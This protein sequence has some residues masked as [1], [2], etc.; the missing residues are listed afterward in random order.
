MNKNRRTDQVTAT[1]YALPDGHWDEIVAACCPHM[2]PIIL[3]IKGGSQ[4]PDKTGT[5]QAIAS[6]DTDMV[7]FAEKIRRPTSLTKIIRDKNDIPSQYDLILRGL[8]DGTLAWDY[9]RDRQIGRGTITQMIST[10][11]IIFDPNNIGPKIQAEAKAYYDQGPLA[12]EYHSMIECQ[13]K[14]RDDVANNRTQSENHRLIAG[15]VLLQNIARAV[16]RIRKQWTAK[17]KIL[18]RMFNYYGALDINEHLFQAFINYQNGNAEPFHQI[19]NTFP[20]LH[21][22]DA[23][24]AV[25]YHKNFL[26]EVLFPSWP[27]KIAAAFTNAR[28]NPKT[29]KA[30]AASDDPDLIYAVDLYLTCRV[31]NSMRAVSPDRITKPNHEYV[32]AVARLVDDVLRMSELYWHLDKQNCTLGSLTQSAL[33]NTRLPGLAQYAREALDGTP[34]HLLNMAKLMLNT[35]VKGR[36]GLSAPRTS[37]EYFRF[38]DSAPPP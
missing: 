24:N 12:I 31:E 2:G 1:S 15:L 26:D 35:L 6:S 27:D 5:I 23:E 36:V 34:D 22:P 16:L 25:P 29:L 13:Q 37:P 21:V 17:G 10:G 9:N 38:P 4:V 7:L 20:N 18:A 11:Q 30:Y 3:A 33:S 19:L 28:Q 8:N 14:L 32:Y